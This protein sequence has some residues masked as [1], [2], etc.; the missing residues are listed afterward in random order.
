MRPQIPGHTAT[1]EG[2]PAVAWPSREPHN[3]LQANAHDLKYRTQCDETESQ[4][5]EDLDSL[6][7]GIR[8]WLPLAL[9]NIAFLWI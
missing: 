7:E 4:P 2:A 9:R 1:G 8:D 3:G 6:Q 5:I